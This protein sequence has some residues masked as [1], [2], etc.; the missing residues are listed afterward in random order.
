MMGCPA[1]L[2]GAALMP[3]ILWFE[4]DGLASPAITS[5]PAP[6]VSFSVLPVP[7]GPRGWRHGVY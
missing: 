7:G 6:Q 4:G 5:A 3:A 2:A 1:A